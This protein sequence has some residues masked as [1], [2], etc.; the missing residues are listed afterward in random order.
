MIQTIFTTGAHLLPIEIKKED[1]RKYWIWTV[2]E[3]VDDSYK[4]GEVFNP[5]ESA[6]SLENLLTE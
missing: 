2:A 4:D 5:K 3:F 6:E 1:G